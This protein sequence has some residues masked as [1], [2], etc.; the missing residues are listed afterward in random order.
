MQPA[1]CLPDVVILFILQVQHVTV[2]LR[3][4]VSSA[5]YLPDELTEMSKQFYRDIFRQNFI[6]YLSNNNLLAAALSNYHNNRGFV[7]SLVGI[8]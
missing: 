6:S 3:L 8:V 2:Q 5:D 4:Q 1:G 7:C